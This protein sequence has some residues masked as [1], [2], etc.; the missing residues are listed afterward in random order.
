MGQSIVHIKNMGDALRNSGYKSID[1]ALSEIIDNSIEAD[2]HD[3]FV[4]MSEKV[5]PQ[6]GRKYVNEF[7]IL[8]NGTGMEIQKLASCLGIGF[9]TKRDR[10]GMGRFGVGLPQASLHVTP[11]VDVYSWQDEIE[12]DFDSCDP[13]YKV[14]L[15]IDKVKSGEQEEIEDPVLED[16]PKKYLKYLTYFDGKMQY[17]FTKHGTLV[18][19]KNCDNVKPKTAGPLQNTLEFA[20]GRKFRHLIAKGTHNIKLIIIGNEGSAINVMPNDPLM[21]MENNYVLGNPSDPGNI[22]PRYNKN[23]TEPVFE[24]FRTDKCPDGEVKL[25]ITYTDRNTHEEKTSDVIIRFSK[26]RD[27]FYDI[28]AFPGKD[29]GNSNLGKHLKK[30]EGISV[31]RAGREIDFGNFDFYSTENSPYHRWWGCEICFD[32]VLDEHFGVANNKQQ[33]E[34]R[35]ETRSENIDDNDSMWELLYPIVKKTID[36]MVEENREK[37]RNS[38]KKKGSETSRTEEIITQI[39][40]NEPS[41]GVTETVVNNSTA[42]QLEERAKEKIKQTTGNSNPSY[43]EI[44]ALINKHISLTYKSIGKNNCFVDFDFSLGNVIVSINTDHIF[45]T[46]FIEKMGKD[47]D[48]LLAFELYIG[49]LAESVNSVSVEDED[50]VDMLLSVWDNKLRKYLRSIKKF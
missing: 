9:S 31:V 21:I 20:L 16:I 30:L 32:P 46:E 28:D 29:P 7:A 12:I 11:A 44:R 15:D 6:T 40:G 5:N 27:I 43:E 39:E 4:I 25:P 24:L 19:W 18:H 33:V 36:R 47:S 38:R 26:V 23:C 1:S 50:A 34:L 3:I 22:S 35:Q 8:D 42:E 45:Y 48:E 49:A 17:D 2:A 10:K 14:W 37:R 41:E 13:V